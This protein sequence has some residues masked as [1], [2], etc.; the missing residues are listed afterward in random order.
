MKVN[1]GDKDGRTYKVEV[2]AS[3]ASLLY[4]KKV[5]DE[6][7]GDMI[8][9]PGYVLVIQGGSDISGFPMRYDIRGTG[10]KKVL[11]G[12]G[13]GVR[14]IKKGE[15]RRKTVRGNTISDDITQLNLVVKTAGQ[16][17]LSEIF[18]VRTK[19]EKEQGKR[20]EKENKKG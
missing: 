3:K 17:K 5:G 20:D 2:D 6:V 8:G 18:G 1:I 13:P 11:I 14:G 9:L 16:Q 19:E 4:G 15:K 7:E 12:S 10:K